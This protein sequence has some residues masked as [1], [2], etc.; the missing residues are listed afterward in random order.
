MKEEIEKN[1]FSVGVGAIPD[2]II[3][4]LIEADKGGIAFGKAKEAFENLNLTLDQIKSWSDEKRARTYYF[5][6]RLV[7]FYGFELEKEKMT[8]LS[9]PPVVNNG[10]AFLW[11]QLAMKVQKIPYLSPA[12]VNPSWDGI[13]FLA[14]KFGKSKRNVLS[15]ADR[16]SLVP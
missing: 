14:W 5:V 15:V 7:N 6:L 2:Q 16:W 9:V 8:A 12:F 1:L 4:I 3:G 11:F 10:I 13:E